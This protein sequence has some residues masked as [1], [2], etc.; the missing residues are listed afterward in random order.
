[1]S[2]VGIRELKEHTSEIMRRVREDG[3]TIEV[4]RRGEVIAKI[5]PTESRRSEESIRRF[6]ERMAELRRQISEQLGDQPIDAVALV[7]EQR[8]NFTPDEWVPADWRP[9]Q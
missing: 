4:T 1:M 2:S 5:V 9:E 3:E 8:R 7:Q 6:D